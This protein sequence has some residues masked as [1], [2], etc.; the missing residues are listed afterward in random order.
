MNSIGPVDLAIVLGSGL[1]DL[2]SERAVFRRLS[3][4]EI[5]LPFSALPG[6]AGHA[7]AGEWHGKRVLIFAG[8][9][10]AYQGFHAREVT[11]AIELAA[12]HGAR[13]V[14]LTNAAG[15]VSERFRPGDIMIIA[16]HIN[17]SGL[18]PLIG[19]GLA[20]PFINM[21]DAYSPR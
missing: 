21:T 11:R 3:Y 6:H 14:F 2:L 13:A 1:S 10:H 19:S 17:L 9:A 4:E 7:L 12:E 8:R 20:D 15:S 16:D 18:N 5:A